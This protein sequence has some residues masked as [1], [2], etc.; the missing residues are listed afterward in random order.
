LTEALLDKDFEI[1]KESVIAL[2][3]MGSTAREALPALRLALKDKDEEVAAV[4]AEAI[5]KVE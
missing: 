5:K 1:R 3:G 2:G 4:A